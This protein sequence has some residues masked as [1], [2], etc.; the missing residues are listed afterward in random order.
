VFECRGTDAKPHPCRQR[1]FSHL[2]PVAF[3]PVAVAAAAQHQAV[4]GIV[5]HD[6][7]LPAHLFVVDSKG[8]SLRPA[9]GQ[10]AVHVDRLAGGAVT[11]A[12]QQ[13]RR[14]LLAR[15]ARGAH[16]RLLGRR[17]TG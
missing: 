8:V 14:W 4:I 11:T 1:Q 7:M 9:D 6:R 13:R 3:D 16:H 15:I 12:Q 10:T 5:F 2:L 17:I